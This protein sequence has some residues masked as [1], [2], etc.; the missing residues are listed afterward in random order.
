M[1]SEF[2]LIT[3]RAHYNKNSLN[4]SLEKEDLMISLD[5]SPNYE[6]DSYK[7]NCFRTNRKSAKNLYNEEV[8]C[9]NFLSVAFLP[10]VQETY[11][12]EKKKKD[13]NIKLVKY[14]EGE[15]LS[16]EELKFLADTNVLLNRCVDKKFL[17]DAV[18]IIDPEVLD[19]L[20]LLLAEN[21]IMNYES[22]RNTIKKA[23]LQYIQEFADYKYEKIQQKAE[24]TQKKE[25]LLR[26]NK[27]NKKFRKTLENICLKMQRQGKFFSKNK[28][29][30][31]IFAKMFIQ[32]LKTNLSKKNSEK[33]EGT[34]KKEQLIKNFPQTPSQKRLELKRRKYHPSSKLFLKDKQDTKSDDEIPEE[35]ILKNQFNN[36]EIIKFNL[37]INGPIH[38]KEPNNFKKFYSGGPLPPTRSEPF[39]TPYDPKKPIVVSSPAELRKIITLQKFIRKYL[40]KLKVK[41]LK[42]EPSK[43]LKESLKRFKRNKAELKFCK[44]VK[45]FV[46]LAKNTSKPMLGPQI[47]TPQIQANK[48]PQ[49]FSSK[50][51]FS[52]SQVFQKHPNKL[53]SITTSITKSTK[54]FSTQNSQFSQENTKKAS[55]NNETP[56]QTPGL[57]KHRKL[58]EHAKFYSLS[59]LKDLGFAYTR[60]D[61]NCKDESNNTALFYAA[62]RGLYDFCE[63]LVRL[64]AECNESCSEK[65]TPL[66][67]AFK[68][69]KIPI[70]TLLL[71]HGGDL[72]IRN[73]FG[74]TAKKMASGKVLKELDLKMMVSFI[75]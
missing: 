21:I 50:I 16:S 39:W 57:L 71:K 25:E 68:S 43:E 17:Q 65:N 35:E 37:M 51:P 6:W 58:I 59:N 23:R 3:R 19:N 34:L 14:A 60:G 72:N 69:G 20:E 52:I 74:N 70:I 2:K 30:K 63:F 47:Y 73:K 33:N 12:E 61:V 10:L 9:S 42:E 48:T 26:K 38:Y 66:H 24:E 1:N 29:K 22:L 46:D 62:E 5:P 32:K 15:W 36:N 49:F 27:E 28:E 64:G 13:R 56:S 40:A 45:N 75:N 44:N 8:K 31:H 55:S 7:E 11:L 18:N 4:K 41:S 54:N 53:S 67:M